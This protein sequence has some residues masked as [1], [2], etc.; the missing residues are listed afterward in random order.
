MRCPSE[1][2]PLLRSSSQF[3]AS[4]RAMSNGTLERSRGRAK[5]RKPLM[6]RSSRW[7]SLSR[8]ST[9][10]RCEGLVLAELDSICT[11]PEMA[12]SGLP[13]SCARPAAS[14]P[15]AAMRSLMRSSSSSRRQRVKSWKMTM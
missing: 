6:V 8:M 4:C 14:S 1:T 9:S 5:R 2:S 15:T 11:E 10:L 12:A 7:L 3:S 13:I